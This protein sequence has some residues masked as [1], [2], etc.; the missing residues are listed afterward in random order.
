MQVWDFDPSETVKEKITKV[1]EVKGVKG[2]RTFLKDIAKTATFCK[3]S[4]ELIGATKIPLNVW[5]LFSFYFPIVYE[6]THT[7]LSI[8]ITYVY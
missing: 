6:F 2:A 5:L 7:N 8:H 4:N 1:R 3:H